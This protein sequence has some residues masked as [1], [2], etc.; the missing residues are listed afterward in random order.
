MTE[1]EVWLRFACAALE[2][3]A[4]AAD[5]AANAAD[6]MLLEYKKRFQQSPTRTVD[7]PWFRRDPAR[8]NDAT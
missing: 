6:L 5:Y 7:S 1:A 3:R 4:N 2:W 8:T